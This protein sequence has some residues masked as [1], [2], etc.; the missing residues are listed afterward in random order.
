MYRYTLTSPAYFYS[1]VGSLSVES[2]EV[3]TV[4]HAYAAAADGGLAL[5]SVVFG[6]VTAAGEEE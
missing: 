3:K 6:K 5:A 2:G 4:T 1:Q